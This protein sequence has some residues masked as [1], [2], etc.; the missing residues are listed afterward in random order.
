M[1]AWIVRAAL[2]GPSAFLLGF[3]AMADSAWFERHVVLP[4]LYNAPPPWTLPALRL[5]ATALGLVLAACAVVAARRATPGSFA[6]V[7]LA[8][9]LSVGAWEPA[10]RVLYRVWPVPETRLEAH[11]A[12][13]D[14]RTGWAFVPGRSLDLPTPGGGRVIRYAID[15]HGDRAAAASWIEDPQAPTVLIAGESIATGHGLLWDETFAARLGGLLQAQVVVT[16]EGGYGS[17]QAH[18]RAVDAL[19]R[20]AHPLAVVTTVLPVQ[21]YRNLHDDRPHLV[22]RDGALEL[23]PASGSNLRLRQLLVNDLP[24]LSDASLRRS[25]E[26]TRAILHATAAAARA[27][28]AAALFVFPNFGPPRPLEAHAEAFMV[29][30]LVDD[31]PHIVVDI[32]P[33]HRLPVD[34]HPDPEGARQI[35]AAIAEALAR[36]G[37]ER[38]APNGGHGFPPI[39]PGGI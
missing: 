28:G 15:A 14:P 34:G 17:D 11:L 37:G 12:A 8:V 23:A 29:S 5:A 38:E 31:L 13:P 32:D 39:G 26:L 18:L 1:L 36:G 25:L 10:L 22:L 21:L 3:A 24:Y 33:S 4:A 20:L 16:A 7:T 35:A 6:R 9:A 30:G 27:R 19:A 2:L